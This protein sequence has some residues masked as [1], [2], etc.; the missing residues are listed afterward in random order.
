MVV[1]RI[2][3]EVNAALAGIVLVASFAQSKASR[4]MLSDKMT[5]SRSLCGWDLSAMVETQGS[6]EKGVQ[7]VG[8]EESTP[9][10]NERPSCYRTPRASGTTR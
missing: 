7:R 3:A 9:N 8:R 2:L 1:R 10:R 4:A 6:C 5:P